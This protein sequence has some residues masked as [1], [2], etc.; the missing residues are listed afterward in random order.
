MDGRCFLKLSDPD[1]KISYK[2]FGKIE[3]GHQKNRFEF[4]KQTMPVFEELVDTGKITFRWPGYQVAKLTLMSHRG[5]GIGLIDGK[6]KLTSDA[7]A[8]FVHIKHRSKNKDADELRL[9]FP[10]S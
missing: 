10:G 9:G 6:P 2:I 3:D 1:G 4:G 7:N 8:I 5:K